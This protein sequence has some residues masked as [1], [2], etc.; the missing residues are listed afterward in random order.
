[1]KKQKQLMMKT[2]PFLTASLFSLLFLGSITHLAQPSWA[3]Q[4]L[5]SPSATTQSLKERI[6]KI[7]EE[8]KEAVA[9][10][11]TQL[12][13]KKKGFIGQVDRVNEEAITITNP[14]GSRILALDDQVQLLKNNEIIPV[15]DV[16]VDDWLIVLGYAE[17]D[18]FVPI[19]LIVASEDL[20]PR[21]KINILGSIQEI[22]TNSL[23]VTARV[24]QQT[25]QFTLDKNTQ[26][27]DQ[28]GEEITKAE[29]FE[30]MQV[31]VVGYKD[32]AKEDQTSNSTNDA[33]SE[34]DAP[35]N[36]AL[37]VRSLAPLEE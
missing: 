10:K 14:K 25:Y 18:D 21:P 37:V 31:L 1:M 2:K 34:K 19:K 28:T 35:K 27:Q 5:A 20:S 3:Q 9:D 12:A 36:V 8:K 24:D 11:L 22:D 7:I 23:Q 26:Y 32:V 29:L 30:D 15:E 6:E 33:N 13:Q 17:E 4:E 16:A